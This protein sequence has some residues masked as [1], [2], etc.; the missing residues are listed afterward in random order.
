MKAPDSDDSKHSAEDDYAGHPVECGDCGS[1]I[2]MRWDAKRGEYRL[3]CECAFGP[4]VPF[5][6]EDEFYSE[7][8]RVETPRMRGEDDD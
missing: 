6:A 3:V 1:S 5:D 4:A 8:E 7:W 2:V